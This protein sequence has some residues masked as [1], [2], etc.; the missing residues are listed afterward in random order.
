MNSP[1]KIEKNKSVAIIKIVDSPLYLLGQES[2]Y[3][4][5]RVGISKLTDGKF[6]PKTRNEL[7]TGIRE[8][9]RIDLS[10]FFPETG[11][12]SIDSV[13]K[14]MDVLHSDHATDKIHYVKGGIAIEKRAPSAYGLPKGGANDGETPEMTLVRELKEELGFDFFSIKKYF[15]GKFLFIDSYYNTFYI[16]VTRVEADSILESYLKISKGSEL[17]NPDFFTIEQINSMST[18]VV[19]KYALNALLHYCNKCSGSD[20]SC[21]VKEIEELKWGT[22]ISR[23]S[24]ASVTITPTFRTRSESAAINSFFCNNCKLQ[25][26]LKPLLGGMKFEKNTCK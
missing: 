18:N 19:T 17:F 14:I 26:E 24:S 11:K 16:P 22:H 10:G 2:T 4:G 3:D 6:F 20:K 23:Y 15:I 9:F 12:D 13:D 5:Y 7:L 1:R 8:K 21:S 25:I